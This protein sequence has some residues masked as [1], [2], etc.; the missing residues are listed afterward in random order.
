MP[1]TSAPP[2]FHRSLSARLLVLTVLFVMLAQVL[3]FAP[4]IGR[5]RLEYLTERL[6]QA[7]L[8]LLA[9]EATEIGRASCRERV[10][11]TV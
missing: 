10:F 9:L 1:E 5:Y 11:L 6:A 4:S 8:A 2:P 3:I 7:H